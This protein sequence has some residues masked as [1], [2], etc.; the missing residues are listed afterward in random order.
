LA[1]R[2]GSDGVEHL[3]NTVARRCISEC[4]D[5][6]Q[7]CFRPF[8]TAG[9]DSSGMFEVAPAAAGSAIDGADAADRATR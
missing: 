8:T 3:A 2:L 1:D 5:Q 4:G 7:S 6:E 9:E